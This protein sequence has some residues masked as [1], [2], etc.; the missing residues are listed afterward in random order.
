MTM[1]SKGYQIDPNNEIGS[2]AAAIIPTAD[3]SRYV[4]APDASILLGVSVEILEKD[5]GSG[6]IIQDGKPV[7]DWKDDGMG[8]IVDGKGQFVGIKVR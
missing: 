1:L 8:R 3:N 5:P 6:R 2:T 4:A 7:K